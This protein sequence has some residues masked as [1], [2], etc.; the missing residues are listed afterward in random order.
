[1][2]DSKEK[3]QDGGYDDLNVSHIAWEVP[4]YQKDEKGQCERNSDTQESGWGW[5][6]Q[7]ELNSWEPTWSSS[8]AV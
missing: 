7:W 1:M 5:I 8:D 6:L 2:Q 3:A 4:L